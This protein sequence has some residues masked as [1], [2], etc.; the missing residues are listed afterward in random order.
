MK[1][2]ALNFQKTQMKQILSRKK[3]MG[4]HLLAIHAQKFL[5]LIQFMGPIKIYL[6]TEPQLFSCSL[7]KNPFEASQAFFSIAEQC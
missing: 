3:P 7:V 5:A 1:V 6:K 4:D 2:D